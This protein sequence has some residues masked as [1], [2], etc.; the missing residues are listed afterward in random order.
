M[1]GPRLQ[2]GQETDIQEVW[3]LKKVGG[4][5]NTHKIY[6]NIYFAEIIK[7]LVWNLCCYGFIY[8]LTKIRMCK[9]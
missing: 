1:I 4:G 7:T 6:I 8:Q 5:R 9:F 2:E 3:R